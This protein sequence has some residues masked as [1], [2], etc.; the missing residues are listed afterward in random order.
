MANAKIKLT[1]SVVDRIELPA[2]GK[3][4]VWD[5]EQTGFG[6]A[7]TAQGVKSWLINYRTRD[8]RQ[9]RIVLGRCD[10]LTV[11]QARIEARG[12]LSEVDKGG[13][14][15]T[16]RRE[17][18]ARMR[19]GELLDQYITDEMP[20]RKRASTAKLHEGQ[21]ERHI[22]PQ[23]G[24]MAVADISRSD[25][26]ALHRR[27]SEEGGPITGNRMVSLLSAIMSYAITIECITANPAFR[28]PRHSEQSRRRYLTL[29]EL[30]KVIADLDASPAQDS[31]D[32]VRL[33]LYTGARVG[34]VL[35]MR[36]DNLDFEIGVWSKPAAAT[37]QKRDH[38][39]PLTDEAQA[40]LQARQKTIKGEWVFPARY[41]PT[42]HLTTIRVFWK[43]VCK[44]TGIPDCHIH[45]LRHTFASLA[46]R[47]GVSLQVV[48]GLLGHSDHKTTNRYLHL[49]DDALREGAKAVAGL[50][51]TK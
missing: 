10:R 16:E 19:M 1:K 39:L 37:K 5:T 40:L 2:D 46:A 13:D 6:V 9:R 28:F 44:R 43:Q 25:V 33:L 38:H 49:Y 42:G 11:D 48:G 7:V 3:I 50:M 32:A 45:D 8:G 29:A 35:A 15:A 4:I 24:S 47:Q 22:R 17:L 31:A 27:A 14:P 23:L 26:E 20:R 12:K 41:S 51:T 36:W 34:E 30:A 21:I 18:R